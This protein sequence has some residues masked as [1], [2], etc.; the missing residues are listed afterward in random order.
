[1]YLGE[2]KAPILPENPTIWKERFHLMGIAGSRHDGDQNDQK[3]LSICIDQAIASRGTVA[4]H[5]E[6]KILSYMHKKG[7]MRKAMNNIGVSKLCCPG[8]FEF[9][10][11]MQQPEV[12][13]A[14]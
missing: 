5:A 11:A 10:R 6:V 1:M 4:I 8:C 2:Q 14:G 3:N 7:L 9:A 13:I 12:I